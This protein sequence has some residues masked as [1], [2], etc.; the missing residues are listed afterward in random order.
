MAD[1]LAL[2]CVRPLYP[3]RKTAQRRKFLGHDGI[4][5][6][7]YQARDGGDRHGPCFAPKFSCA[8]IV[9]AFVATTENEIPLH[10]GVAVV[11]V[12]GH[13]PLAALCEFLPQNGMM[14]LDVAYESRLVNKPKGHTN[15]QTEKGKARN[16]FWVRTHER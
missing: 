4:E 14:L 12:F 16:E 9:D 8:G 10:P 2:I 1:L 5:A 13:E 3:R 7:Y 11:R 15:E 6:D